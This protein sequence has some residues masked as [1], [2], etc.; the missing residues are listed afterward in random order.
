MVLESICEEFDG[1]KYNFKAEQTNFS[2]I[3]NKEKNLHLETPQSSF[4]FIN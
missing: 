2:P 1:L 4:V 3:E